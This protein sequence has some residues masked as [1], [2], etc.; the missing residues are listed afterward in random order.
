[1]SV[2]AS[3]ILDGARRMAL[4]KSKKLWSDTELISTLND[5]ITDLRNLHPEAF[6]E[7]DIDPADFDTPVEVAAVTDLIDIGRR[8]VSPLRHRILY[9]LYLEDTESANNVQL[10]S[11][12]NEA[13]MREIG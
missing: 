9:Y 8:F 13:W 6:M 4:D 10:A 2:L 7:S 5:A 12:H 11:S 3:Q 1:M